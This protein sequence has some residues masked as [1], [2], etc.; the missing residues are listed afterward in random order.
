MVSSFLCECHGLLK[1]DEQLQKEY[2]GIASDSTVST[3]FLKPGANS[4]GY[5]KNSELVAQVREKVLPIFRV[6]HPNCD[7]VFLFDNSQNHH[8]KTPDALSTLR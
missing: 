2:P 7:G 3:V 1:F 4:E 6:L 8:A 5:W